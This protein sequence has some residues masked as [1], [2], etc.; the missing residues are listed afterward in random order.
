MGSSSRPK[1]TIQNG[2]DA[3]DYMITIMEKWRIAMG[4]LTDFILGAHS[5]GAYLGGTYAAKYP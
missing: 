3:D 4:N 1:W 2:D 5:Y